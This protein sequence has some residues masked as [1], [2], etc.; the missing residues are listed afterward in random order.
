[1]PHDNALVIT[2]ELASTIF[3]TVLVDIGSAVNIV[4]QKT[5]RSISQPTPVIDHETTH[6]NSFK[7]KSVR[8]LGIVPLTT[9]TYDVELETRFTIV[10][11]FMPFDAIVGRPRLHQMKRSLRFTTSA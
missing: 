7:G 1:M 4:S 9:K 5:L 3:S 8:T 11:H 6:L 2:L 10:D